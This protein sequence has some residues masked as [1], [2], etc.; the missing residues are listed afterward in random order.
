MSDLSCMLE[1]E[2]RFSVSCSCAH[3]EGMSLI[4]D[5]PLLLT[6]GFPSRFLVSVEPCPSADLFST[7]SRRISA[8]MV[9]EG[10]SL[11]HLG[12]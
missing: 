6:P 11:G 2:A 9:A 4:R 7:V 1:K 8:S 3:T 5:E 12:I 10:V